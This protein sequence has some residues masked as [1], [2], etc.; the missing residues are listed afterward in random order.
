MIEISRESMHGYTIIPVHIM[1]IILNNYG[2]FKRI[3]S[4]W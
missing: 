3:N 1:H 4:R 2:P